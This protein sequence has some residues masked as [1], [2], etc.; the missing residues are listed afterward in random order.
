LFPTEDMHGTHELVFAWKGDLRKNMTEFLNY[1]QKEL[2]D[3]IV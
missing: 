1:L 3:Q 2:A